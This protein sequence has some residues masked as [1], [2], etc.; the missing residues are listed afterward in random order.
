MIDRYSKIEFKDDIVFKTVRNTNFQP[1]NQ[2]W[3]KHYSNLS[4]SNPALVKVLGLVD[5]ETYTMEFLDIVDTIESVLKREEYY[6]LITKD[7]ICD[8]IITINNTW[9]QSMQE[10]K[11]LKNNTFFVNCDLSL[12][13][14]VLTTSN[15]VKIIDPESFTF[16]QNLEYTEKYY[17]TQINLMSN[18]QT[19][20]ARTSVK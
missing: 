1:I 3:L 4:K 14:I 11:K 7:L 16:V 13:N 15:E 18:L 5:H 19:Y 6:H 9:S 2:Q 10:S 20:Y 17:M 8:I 12:S